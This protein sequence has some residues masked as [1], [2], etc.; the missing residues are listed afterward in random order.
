M[1]AELEIPVRYAVQF[2]EHA[3]AA[4]LVH[5]ALAL[6]AGVVFDAEGQHVDARQLH[7]AVEP[8]RL[9]HRAGLLFQR[10]FAHH[11]AGQRDAVFAAPIAELIGIGADE[12]LGEM[13]VI[14]VAGDGIPL[15]AVEENFRQMR[16]QV[17]AVLRQIRLR[18]V[19]GERDGNQFAVL[20]FGEIVFEGK[21]RLVGE[22]R[23]NR[24]AELVADGAVIRLVRYVDERAHG[25]QIEQVRIGRIVE[26]RVVARNLKIG[27][28]ERVRIGG[29]DFF[30]RKAAV[31]LQPALR[32]ERHRIDGQQ[33]AV[34]AARAF[35]VGAHAPCVAGFH[36]AQ[37]RGREHEQAR[38]VAVVLGDVAAAVTRGPAILVVEPGVHAVLLCT[39]HGVT[40]ARHELLLQ[41]RQRHARAGM[42]LRAVHAHFLE[43]VGHEI[44]V[45]VRHRAVPRPE[46]R[47]AVFRRRVLK[48][49]FAVR[50]VFL[51]V[52]LHIFLLFY[53]MNG[54]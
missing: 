44:D 2:V 12:P 48:V 53:G 5:C 11:V 54:N 34:V 20:R 33:R 22:N 28:P 6:L 36:V 51:F 8:H 43:H 4:E 16:Q 7:F 9:A 27:V 29:R 1:A 3:F 41:I 39:F 26:P 18:Q 42:Q 49:R 31:F 17:F 23:R 10:G 14:A 13:I 24:L 46:R 30:R 38:T 19:V 15:F 47:A 40:D 35:A 52:K 45:F 25:L 21:L 37:R 50:L 32:V